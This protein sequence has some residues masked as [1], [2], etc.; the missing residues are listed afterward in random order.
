[1]QITT[2]TNACMY[3]HTHPHTHT[4]HIRLQHIHT[5][6]LHLH[7]SSTSRSIPLP[8]V[9]SVSCTGA[10]TIVW[11]ATCFSFDV[12]AFDHSSASSVPAST[13]NSFAPSLSAA[14]KNPRKG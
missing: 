13:S 4:L 8:S 1:M 2:C 9:G 5:P 11:V 14:G 6:A 3:T 12:T 7:I 10:S